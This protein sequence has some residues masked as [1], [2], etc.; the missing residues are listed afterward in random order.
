MI[1]ENIVLGVCEFRAVDLDMVLFKCKCEFR[2]KRVTLVLNKGAI[3]GSCSR[4]FYGFVFDVKGDERLSLWNGINTWLFPPKIK[5][6]E[7]QSDKG[8]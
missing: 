8:F 2:V 3:F 7:I 5:D 1:N 6:D 4:G